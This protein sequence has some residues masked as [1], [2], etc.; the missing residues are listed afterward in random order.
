MEQSPAPTRGNRIAARKSLSL[1]RMGMELMDRKRNILV[2]EMMSLLDRAGELRGAIDETFTSAYGALQRANITM[3]YCGEIAEAMPVEESLAIS[4]RSVMGVELPTVRLLNREMTPN[5]DMSSTNS[6]FDA[7][8]IGFH[9]AKLLTV[10]LAEV[11]NS[12][13]RL[14]D[15]IKK[16]QSRSNAL[17]NVIIPRLVRIDREITAA[18]EEKERE[19]FSRMKLIKTAK[20]S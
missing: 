6:A 3:G 13:F 15:A 16:T 1:A 19:E 8:F 10:E 12:V 11:E 9:R 4:L 20:R 2:R 17:S 18:L 7:A 5:Y 14:A